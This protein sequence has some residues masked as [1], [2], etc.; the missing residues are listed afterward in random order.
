MVRSSFCISIWSSIYFSL[1]FSAS[2]IQAHPNQIFGTLRASP[3]SWYNVAH[4]LFNGTSATGSMTLMPRESLLQPLVTTSKLPRTQMMMIHNHQMTMFQW[5]HKLLTHQLPNYSKDPFASVCHFFC[6]EV[7]G[8]LSKMFF[9][10]VAT[11]KY[12]KF[13]KVVESELNS[14]VFL[15]LASTTTELVSQAWLSAGYYFRAFPSMAFL[16]ELQLNALRREVDNLEGQEGTKEQ[17]V[18]RVK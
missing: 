10:K 8:V 6:K 7:L 2:S 11:S 14:K 18:V 13:I 15:F 5:F 9:S 12:V 17:K 1:S 3:I 16:S 4:S